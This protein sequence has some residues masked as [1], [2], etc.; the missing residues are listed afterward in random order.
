[1]TLASLHRF[2]AGF[3]VILP[4][5]CKT[6]VTARRSSMATGSADLKY[7]HP[8]VRGLHRVPT[9]ISLFTERIPCC[10]A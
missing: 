6:S 7:T 3:V 4:D 10:P 5:L 2:Q 9:V 1:M 8:A